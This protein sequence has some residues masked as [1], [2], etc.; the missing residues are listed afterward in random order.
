MAGRPLLYDERNFKAAVEQYF[1]LVQGQPTKAGL[2]RH[3]K[4]SR[5][6]W[7]EYK[8]RDEFVDAIRDAELLIEDA[9]N[10]QLLGPGASGPIFYLKNAFK[11]HYRDR[12]ELDHTSDGHPLAAPI[13]GMR[14]I[15]DAKGDTTEGNR[16]QE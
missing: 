13:I 3:L 4:I 6:T 1:Q 7:R 11:E 8:E 15:D 2:L 10:Q 16:V 14:I 12:Q 5:E 9:W